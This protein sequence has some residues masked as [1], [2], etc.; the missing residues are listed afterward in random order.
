ARYLASGPDE[1][2]GNQYCRMSARAEGVVQRSMRVPT[3]LGPLGTGSWTGH[4]APSIAE[5]RKSMRR[6]TTF[7]EDS[8]G[9]V[10]AWSSQ[11]DSSQFPV[12]NV[13]HPEQSAE[14]HK[15]GTRNRH[16]TEPEQKRNP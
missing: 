1:V 12:R 6:T 14:K 11:F 16:L 4:A 10:A 9:E 8:F 5:R 2:V 3:R 13:G 7:V 15:L